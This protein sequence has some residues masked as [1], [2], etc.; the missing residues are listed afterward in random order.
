M[1]MMPWR[2]A[3][4][5]MSA[6]VWRR[7]AGGPAGASLCW[8]SSG[9]ASWIARLMVVRFTPSRWA[10]RGQGRARCRCRRVARTRSASVTLGGGAGSGSPFRPAPPPLVAVL[11][12][13]G[14]PWACKRGGQIVQVVAGQPGQ[15]GVGQRGAVPSAGGSWPRFRGPAGLAR[16]RVEAVI[17]VAVEVVAGDRQGG[18]LLIADLDTGGV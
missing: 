1:G 15:R 6:S 11:L 10:S 17:P 9:R 3:Y 16:V 7:A 4:A 12:P 18:H 5:E 14:A 2:A 13:L 8:S